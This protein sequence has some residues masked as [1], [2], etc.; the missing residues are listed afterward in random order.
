MKQNTINLYGKT[1]D[2]IQAFV[3]EHELPKF[4]ARQLAEWIYQKHVHRFSEM[5]NISKK[6]RKLLE[7]TAEIKFFSPEK[8]SISKDGTKKYLFRYPGKA[9]IE[10]V[11]IPDE[12]RNTLCISSQSGCKYN[13]E[14]CMTGKL[15]FRGQLTPGEIINQFQNISERDRITN[16]VYMG[17]GEPLD[18]LEN[19][20]KS[21]ELFTEDYAFAMSKKRITVSTIGLLPAL[22]QLLE[23]SKVHIALSMHSPFDAIR[24][25]IM[26]VQKAHQLSEVMKLLKTYD[27]TGD[28]RLFVEYIM[29]KNL[30]DR[31]EDVNKLTKI[32]HGL[33]CRVNLI[34]FHE[35]PGIQ[36][37][38]SSDEAIEQFRQR[39]REKGIPARLRKSRGRDI[40]AA[41][42][43]LS[44]KNFGS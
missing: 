17:M 22:K 13:C 23:H 31:P 27:F 38:G 33:R 24:R 6:N 16:I 20:L 2:E 29:L 36:L 35:I 11:L 14:F 44:G 41:C 21:I 34:R 42:G 10:A 19:V 40:E 26:P 30:N 37:A 4:T 39:L 25:E 5:T 3:K 1:L 8:F 28:R 32:L 18:N 7:E 43:M 12:E 9:P 15:G